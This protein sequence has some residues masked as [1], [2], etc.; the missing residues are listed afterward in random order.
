MRIAFLGTSSFACPALRALASAHEISLAVTQPDRPAGRRREL[1]V[2]PVKKAALDLGLPIAQIEKINSP[3]GIDCLREATPEVTVVAS[4]GQLLTRRVFS[5]PQHGT[6]NIH[7]SLLPRYRGCAPVNW[8]IIR[9]E[10]ITGVTTFF[11][12]EGMDTGDILLQ[13]PCPI[14]PNETAGQLHDHLALLGA[15]A[16]LETLQIIESGNPSP[17][18]QQDEEATIAPKLSRFDGEIKWNNKACHIHNLVRGLNPWPGA[19]THLRNER[20]KIHSTLLTGVGCG[21]LAPGTI[22]LQESGRLLVATGKDLIEILEIQRENHAI[23]SGKAFLNG[24]R[25]DSRFS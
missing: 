5:L 23:T 19:Y 14:G 20:V 10:K 22:A 11:I 4:Y 17:I 6:I 18:P 1:R 15:E 25:G 2:S 12:E 7:A 21:K 8:A 16:I 13:R 24:L 9:G 3:Q